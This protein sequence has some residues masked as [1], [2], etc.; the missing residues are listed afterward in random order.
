VNYLIMPLGSHG[1]VHPFLGIA[2]T[3]R[4][5]GHS[6]KV[7]A[8]A[9]YDSLIAAMGLDF[10]PLGEAEDFVAVMRDPDIWHPT[11]AFEIISK[12]VSQVIPLCYQAVADHAVAGGGG[13]TVLVYSTLA[14]GA[15]MAQE[16]LN[17]PG[18]SIHLSP[19]IFQSVYA[20]PCLPGIYMPDWM[21]YWMKR[22]IF[23]LLDRFVLDRLFARPLNVIRKEM[24]LPPVRSVL[25][26]WCHS[27]Q[28]V[29]GLFPEWYAPIQP[30][31]PEQTVLTG[32]PLFDE[33]GVTPLPENLSHFLAAGEKPIVFTPGS[34]N[35]HG[36]DFF[37]AA[38]DACRRL[39]RRGVLLTRHV[40]QIPKNLPPTVLHVPYAPFSQLLPHTAASVHH[41]GIGTA[42]QAMA[43]GVPQLLMPMG[44][45]QPD[46]A[47]RIKK[48]GIGDSLPPKHFTGEAAA[49]K[50]RELISSE[51]TAAACRSVADKFRTVESP[52]I[53]TARRI[54]EITPPSP[55]APASSPGS[56]THSAHP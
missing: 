3:L 36:Q 33:K 37:A 48:L 27:P 44:Y 31:W 32:F 49:A 39:N 6:V 18:V 52:L 23:N 26:K 29:I 42:A 17:L 15:R 54:E 14:F 25:G 9:Y 16:T 30:D 46:N 20:P 35:M 51:K 13:N 28:R 12:S 10:V 7:I 40:E 19:S 24:G 55:P 22:G 43:A 1:D 8:S 41:G 50:L 45:D 34:A 5:R 53:Q 4:S 56:S 21:P 38:V 47:D 11:R 2:S